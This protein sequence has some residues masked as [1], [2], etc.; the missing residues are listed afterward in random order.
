MTTRE[1]PVGPLRWFDGTADIGG[2]RI[3]GS[4]TYD[5]AGDCYTLVA[6]GYNMWGV[7]DECQFAWTRLRGDF[8]IDARVE[9]VGS[10]TEPHCKAGCMVRPTL[11][12]D[13][14]Y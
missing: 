1:G 4:T 5:A 8:V 14:P 6:G 7:R 10:G 3:A 11:D 9:F 2:P 13:A 12:D